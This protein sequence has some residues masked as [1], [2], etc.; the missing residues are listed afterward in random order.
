[1]PAAHFF[2]L[3]SMMTGPGSRGWTLM[4]DGDLATYNGWEMAEDGQS[5]RWIGVSGRRMNNG[6]W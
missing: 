3:D 2:G 4:V 6:R 5:R 1:M